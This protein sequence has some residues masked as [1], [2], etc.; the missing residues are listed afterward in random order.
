[1]DQIH[2]KKTE[3]EKI[4]CYNKENILKNG[5]CFTIDGIHA[6]FL[7]L[8]PKDGEYVQSLANI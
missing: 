3:S 4:I 2:V 1:M 6:Y 7:W 8:H 5:W